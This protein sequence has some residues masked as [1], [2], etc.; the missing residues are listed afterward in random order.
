VLV[1]ALNV[2][3]IS[4]VSLGEIP[5]GPAREWREP[6]PLPGARGA[7]MGRFNLGST[8]VLVFGPNAVRWDARLTAG[9]PL[10]MGESIG[11]IL[12][13]AAPLRPAANGRAR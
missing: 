2:S 4:T 7:E 12:G 5:S 10:K 9:M 11:R 8:V 1:G 3:S 6:R 13:D